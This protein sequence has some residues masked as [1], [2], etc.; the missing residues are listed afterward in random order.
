MG[1][2]LIE[3]GVKGTTEKCV[4]GRGRSKRTR[5]NDVWMEEE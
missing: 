1:G 4:L 2:S 3:G 5:L